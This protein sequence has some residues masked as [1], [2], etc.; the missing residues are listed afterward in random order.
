MRI[1]KSIKIK[2]FALR[3]FFGVIVTIRDTLS[4]S[5]ITFELEVS[6]AAF[7]ESGKKLVIVPAV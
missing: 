6:D 1:G 2:P 3:L 5:A 7:K 4:V